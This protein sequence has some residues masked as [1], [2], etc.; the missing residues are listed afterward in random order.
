MPRSAAAPS[1]TMHQK[2]KRGRPPLYPFADLAVGQSFQI[3][4]GKAR[5][6]A[7][8]AITWARRNA[9]ASRFSISGDA[10]TRLPDRNT[11][12]DPALD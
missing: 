5:A 3:P 9:P 7:S 10:C 6:V 8:S 2:T 4:P 11:N 12:P 1:T